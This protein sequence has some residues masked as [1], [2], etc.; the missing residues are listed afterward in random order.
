MNETKDK[1][2]MCPPDYFTV[3]DVINPWMAGNE[4]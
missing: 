1:V 4:G 2:L 3:D